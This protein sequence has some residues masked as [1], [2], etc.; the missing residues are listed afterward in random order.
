MTPHLAALSAAYLIGRV[1]ILVD[2]INSLLVD[3]WLYTDQQPALYRSLITEISDL[4][5]VV[6]GHLLT[7]DYLSAGANE[8]AIMRYSIVVHELKREPTA[9]VLESLQNQLSTLYLSTL[10]APQAA[11]SSTLL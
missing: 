2:E 8:P 11:A 10:P 3:S 5:E 4:A 7:L 9:F 6:V 1:A